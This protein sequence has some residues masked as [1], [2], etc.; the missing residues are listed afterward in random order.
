M[1]QTIAK[2]KC[3]LPSE[4]QHKIIGLVFL[5]FI[6]GI[7]ELIG[8][9]G[10]FPIISAITMERVA[11]LKVIV[12]MCAILVAVYFIKN[13]YLMF[14]YKTIFAFVYN[15]RSKLS[16]R[17]FN[18]YMKEK[19]EF[20][21]SRNFSL[22]QRAVRGDVDGCYIVVR[23]LL[24]ILSEMIIC[25]IL[26][27]LLLFTDPVMALFLSLFM[28]LCIGTVLVISKRSIKKIGEAEMYHVGK[29]NQW[30]M[31]GIGGIK[32]IHLSGKENYFVDKYEAH[33]NISARCNSKQQV[34]VLMPRMFTETVCIAGIMLWIVIS[35]LNGQNLLELVPTIAVFAVAAFRL[36]PSVGK[37][38]ALISECQFFKPRIDFIYEDISGIDENISHETAD[39]GNLEFNTNL[40]V[41]NLTFRYANTDKD[42]FS[43]IS[44]VID[45]GE[46]VGIVGP[47]GAGKT[48][49][50]DVIMGLLSPQ[51]GDIKVDDISIYEKLKSWQR[52]IGYVP[53]S[54]YLS[55]DTIRANIAF[56]VPED[57]I[58]DS[59]V[60]D[61]IRKA[62][63]ENFVEELPDGIN[64]L[65]GDRGVRLSGGQR[66]RI[67]I[68]RALY[69]RPEVLILD[70]ATSALD[71]DTETAVMDA[72]EH[73]HGKLT[74]IIIAHRT[75]TL[76][77]C[78][79]IYRVENG[80]VSLE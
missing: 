30:L 38:N 68:A 73:L 40:S 10:V 62:Q 48:T 19:Y 7:L 78:D 12:T 66:Q 25:L 24:Q 47:S 55:D 69:N 22:I 5:M 72:I 18:V 42:I 56:G 15:G 70:E 67:G 3:I 75:S 13:I 61:V 6:G 31:Q 63:L 23:D 29:M 2:L 50:I 37:I 45:Y 71:S 46:S 8:V 80:K 36:L 28:L 4:D 54:I 52:L 11:N 27:G 79:K 53:Q 17:L 59:L 65:V 21:L 76:K 33:S 49:L 26:C 51:D 60:W 14:M 44:L 35:T 34:L 39:I 1:R 77:Q 41:E 74:M 64:T 43:G 57:E 32:E 16:T 20:H 58:D 9:A